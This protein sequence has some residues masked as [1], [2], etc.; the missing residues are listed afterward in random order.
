MN[1]NLRE[2]QK[3]LLRLLVQKARDGELDEEFFVVWV[4]GGGK[5]AELG[6][7][8]PKIP[9]GA[10]DVLENAGLLLCTPNYKI[11]TSGSR[12]R[13]RTTS[14]EINR[15][16]TLTER[17]FD[18]VDNDFELPA[19]D[20]SPIAIGAIINSMSGGNV[21]AVGDARDAQISQIVN[22]PELLRS[23][24]DALVENLVNEV[25]SALELDELAEY[26]QA[27]QDLKEQLL[28]E[29]RDPSLIRK[30][31]RTL[32]LLGDVEGTVGLMARVWSLLYPLLLIAA[33]RLG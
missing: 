4:I 11:T 29:E 14:R 6:R 5:I 12:K 2:S 18:A 21:Q 27:V 16:C 25:K 32:S 17:A 3:D 28:A 9:K 8:S 23:Q 19:S 7:D 24:V 20:P 10:L 15:R 30:L 26:V 31:M 1:Y 33:A 13:P 22:D